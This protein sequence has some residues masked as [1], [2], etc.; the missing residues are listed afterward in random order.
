MNN[1]KDAIRLIKWQ[2][3]TIGALLAAIACLSVFAYAESLY[4]T[5]AREEAKRLRDENRSL[6]GA[7]LTDQS[8]LHLADEHIKNFEAKY[9]PIEPGD[10]CR[11][12]Y[13][14]D[15]PGEAK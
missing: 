12:V 4:A 14:N 7:H 15:D 6:F 11:G 13:C 3:I 2:R 9:G 10:S 8:I 5:A 1:L